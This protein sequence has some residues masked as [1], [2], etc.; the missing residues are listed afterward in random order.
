MK[1][2]SSLLIQHDNNALEKEELEKVIDEKTIFFLFNKIIEE[3]YGKRGRTVIFPAKYQEKILL[4]RVASPLWAQ[5]LITER[6]GICRSLNKS[7]GEEVLVDLQ[8]VHGLTG[9]IHK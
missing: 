8:I 9:D 4:V 2:L 6:G 3:Q 7:L 5:E 1:S